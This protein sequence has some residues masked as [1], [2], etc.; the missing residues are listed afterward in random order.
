MTPFMT[1]LL[2]NITKP[3]IRTGLLQ[4]KQALDNPLIRKFVNA[5]EVAKRSNGKLTPVQAQEI[6]ANWKLIISK[7][8]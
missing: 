7:L 3:E 5:N 6:L 4:L 8:R 1:T 2:A